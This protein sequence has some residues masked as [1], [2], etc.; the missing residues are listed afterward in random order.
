MV[1]E[2]R[3]EEREGGGGKGGKR[4]GGRRERGREWGEMVVKLPTRTITGMNGSYEPPM[5]PHSSRHCF[6]SQTFHACIVYVLTHYIAHM[7][8]NG[9]LWMTQA[10]PCKYSPRMLLVCRCTYICTLC[11]HSASPAT[12]HACQRRYHKCLCVRHKT[13]HLHQT[14]GVWSWHHS[15]NYYLQL[16]LLMR[17]AVHILT[18]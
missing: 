11:H 4:E 6:S 2:G 9:V 5:H 13:L 12:A 3:R 10:V 8:V 17:Q 15:Q 16:C 7:H 1:R 18:E 14:M